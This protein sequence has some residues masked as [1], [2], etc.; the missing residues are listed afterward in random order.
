MEHYS[1][2]K[3]NEITTFAA[4]WMDQEIIMPRE[5]KSDKYKHMIWL[6]CRIYLKKDKNEL[7]YRTETDT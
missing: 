7:I 5:V 3:M 1:S 2:I 4:T 6:I